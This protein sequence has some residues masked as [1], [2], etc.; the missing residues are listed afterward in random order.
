MGESERANGWRFF[1]QSR[2]KNEINDFYHDDISLCV[3]ISF[4]GQSFNHGYPLEKQL[5][6]IDP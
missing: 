5:A 1:E 2:R 3:D 6:S 4:N